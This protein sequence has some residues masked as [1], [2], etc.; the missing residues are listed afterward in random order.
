MPMEADA[1]SDLKSLIAAARRGPL[2]FGVCMGKKPEETVMLLHRTKSAEVLGKSAKK[3]VETA[4]VAFGEIEVSGKKASLTCHEDPPPGI[5]RSLKLFFSKTV[6]MPLKVIL[7]SANGAVLESDGDDDA[8]DTAEAGAAPANAPAAE[9]AA[10]DNNPLLNDLKTRARALAG[11]IGAVSDA[12]ARAKLADALKKIIALLN[13]GNAGSAEPGLEKLEALAARY[14]TPA[15]ANA[16]AAPQHDPWPATRA[17]LEPRVL[18]ALKANH[19]EATKIRA[20]WGFAVEKADAGDIA[21]ALKAAE[22][23]APLL[24]APTAA[25]APD[26]PPQNVVAF[27][28]SRLMW[29][30]AK[31]AMKS[32]LG[33]FRAA[34]DQQSA[35]DEDQ[36]E[37]LS[38]VDGLVDQF[39]AFDD[40]LEDVLDQITNTAEGNA[41]SGLKRQA[42]AAIGRYLDTLDTPFFKIIDE[43]PFV[44]VNVA[45]R[46]KQSLSLVRSTLA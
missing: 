4:K 3:Q 18:A 29:I 31:R 38:A 23:L 10:P 11:Q 9:A 34:V 40:A 45:G 43:N 22:R 39:D 24:D 37:I 33:K 41:R 27:Q 26:V 25:A 6:E 42:A 28:R 44:A 46:A 13:A 36:S 12:D 19:P 7:L 17:G 32:D 1:L 15:P 8:D 30:D 14:A 21:S 16:P 2:A 35:D 20:V 5:A